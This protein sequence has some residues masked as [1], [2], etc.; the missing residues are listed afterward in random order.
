LGEKKAIEI[1]N[2]GDDSTNLENKNPNTRAIHIHGGMEQNLGGYAKHYSCGYTKILGSSE[3][4]R[5]IDHSRRDFSK[6][7]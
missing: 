5:E 1:I 3:F 2:G 7:W 6:H 4:T